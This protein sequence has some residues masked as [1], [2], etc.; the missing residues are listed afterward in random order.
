MSSELEY[1]FAATEQPI[2]PGGPYAPAHPAWRRAAYF[3]VACVTAITA[4][5]GNSLISTNLSNLA[6]SIGEYATA[7]TMLPA[8]YV[9]TIVS[10]NLFLIKARIRWGIPAVTQGMLAVYA[11]AALLQVAF[12]TFAFAAVVRAANGLAGAALIAVTMY[13]LLQVFPAKMRPA[14]LVVGIGLTQLSVP[15]ARLFPI[16]MLAQHHWR[17]LHLIELA[18]PLAAI[19]LLRAVPLPPSDKREVFEPLDFTTLALFAP[20]MLLLC[21]VLSEGRLYWWTDTTWLGWALAGSVPLFAAAILIESLRSKPLLYVDWIG[22][23]GI[24][25]FAAVAL[26]MRIALA[27][28]TFG[29]VGLLA[30]SGL[31]NEQLRTLFAIVLGAMLLGIATAVVTLRPHRVRLQVIAAAVIIA[32]GAWLDSHATNLTGPRELYFSQ[33]LLGFGTTLFIGPAL[34]FGF[35]RMLER[36]PAYFVSLV[37]V[38]SSTQNIGGLAGSALLGSY[39]AI[40][41]R[42]HLSA[43]TDRLVVADPQVIARI[44]AGTQAL[45][46]AVT[47]AGRRAA[48]GVAQLAQAAAREA[49]ILAFNDVFRFVAV[50]ALATALFGLYFVLRDRWRARHPVSREALA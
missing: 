41:T 33:A 23:A 39:Q 20:A 25:R 26:L 18:L 28:Q 12:P 47:D 48:Q 10:A 31:N 19:A 15:L 49:T 17:A 11:L 6:G 2:L 1:R 42:S 7:V 46:G 36:G 32:L 3:G 50:L 34:A 29:S 4:T 16:E 8:I 27:E 30:S 37:V 40:A 21:V 5:L 38:F 35:L 45:A 44:Q 14:A 13:N 24:L 9:A 43:L 22:S